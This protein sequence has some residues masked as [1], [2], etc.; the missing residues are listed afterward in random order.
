M[1]TLSGWF[2]LRL[3][4]VVVALLF[5]PLTSAL[6][7]GPVSQAQ[8]QMEMPAEEALL[9]SEQSPLVRRSVPLVQEGHRASLLAQVV[10]GAGRVAAS[11]V[12]CAADILEC[13]DGSRVTR[14]LPSCQFAPCPT[15]DGGSTVA[16]SP[17][18]ALTLDSPSGNIT[19]GNI[20]SGANESLAGDDNATLGL[21]QNESEAGMGAETVTVTV[22]VLV[23]PDPLSLP[24]LVRPEVAEAL[25]RHQ[26]TA[27]E[28]ERTLQSLGLEPTKE[29]LTSPD[30][31]PYNEATV[32]S[33][34]E[35]MRGEQATEKTLE[36]EKKEEEAM[37][38]ERSKRWKAL[39][40]M[41]LVELVLVSLVLG[42]AATLSILSA[43]RAQKAEDSSKATPGADNW[44]DYYVEG[45]EQWTEAE[46]EE[47][48]RQAAAAPAATAGAQ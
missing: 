44:G 8:L 27:E 35:I 21:P 12:P 11:D 15:V 26:P 29:D 47:W 3:P 19:E 36:A 5:P 22:T 10:D 46:W 38:E 48:M 14:H 25:R 42:V 18:P 28:R 30:M 32:R 43:K 33:G 17:T 16:A 1:S 37:D 13:P 7:G 31:T 6:D 9:L 40:V 2:F 41:L 20:S 23:T 34:V 39:R 24:G 4:V 45:D